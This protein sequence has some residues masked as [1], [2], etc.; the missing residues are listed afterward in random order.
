MRANGAQASTMNEIRPEIVTKLEFDVGRSNEGLSPTTPKFPLNRLNSQGTANM[1]SHLSNLESIYSANRFQQGTPSMTDIQNYQLNQNFQLGSDFGR[2]KSMVF[3]TG[4]STNLIPNVGL[5]QLANNRNSFVNYNQILPNQ[6]LRN[7]DSLQ[8]SQNN[9]LVPNLL[10]NEQLTQNQMTQIKLLNS[11]QQPQSFTALNQPNLQSLNLNLGF[12]SRMRK[13]LDLTQ[14]MGYTEILGPRTIEPNLTSIRNFPTAGSNVSLTDLRSKIGLFGSYEANITKSTAMSDSS[15]PRHNRGISFT[16]PNGTLPSLL[17]MPEPQS[18]GQNPSITSLDEEIKEDVFPQLRSPNLTLSLH[19]QFEG[20]NI[21]NEDIFSRNT[22]S[23]IPRGL[24]IYSLPDIRNDIKMKIEDEGGVQ[25]LY[26]MGADHVP[27][28]YPKEVRAMKI[29]KY[30][31]K[32]IKWRVAHPVN[33]NFSGRSQVAGSKPRIK[34]K[35]VSNE[36]YK[37]FMEVSKKDGESMSGTD[38]LSQRQPDMKIEECS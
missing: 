30:K 8:L 32:I 17:E 12:N 26:R 18:A 24:N 3:G 27:G 34:G 20:L 22:F 31:K 13:N 21:D 36:K 1:K 7:V 35:F 28:V 38:K 33:R 6:V 10:P 29:L 14:N 25:R 4:A 5:S 11:L 37:Q 15:S 16:S 2:A 23:S 19:S 9:L